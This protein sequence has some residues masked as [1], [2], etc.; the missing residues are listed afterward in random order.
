MTILKTKCSVLKLVKHSSLPERCSISE[1][2]TLFSVF[3][4]EV[5]LD[6]LTFRVPFAS[7]NHSTKFCV[8]K[9]R[10]FVEETSFI[11]LFDGQQKW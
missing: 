5:S 3:C 11:L 1:K 8:K 4:L 2:K 10:K 7:E 6:K 9:F